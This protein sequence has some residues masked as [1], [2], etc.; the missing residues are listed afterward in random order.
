[1][2]T[3][4]KCHTYIPHS[5]K[6]YSLPPMATLPN[7]LSCWLHFTG[8]KYVQLASSLTVKIWTAENIDQLKGCIECI[9]WSVM[10]VSSAKIDQATDVVTSYIRFCEDNIVSKK[11]ITFFPTNKP[12]ITNKIRSTLNDKKLLFSQV[13]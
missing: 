9:D 12:W 13:A 3:Y 1:M 4:I 5:Y 10:I 8:Q 11:T 6:S 2:Y 7:T